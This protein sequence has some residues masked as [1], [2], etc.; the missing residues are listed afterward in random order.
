MTGGRL[1]HK[2]RQREGENGRKRESRKEREKE[3]EKQ[4]EDTGERAGALVSRL[5]FC[6]RGGIAYSIFLRL[7]SFY[8][9]CL[10]A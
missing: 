10:F 6:A 4:K 5:L 8:A 7:E 3:R 2:E 9:C 1:F